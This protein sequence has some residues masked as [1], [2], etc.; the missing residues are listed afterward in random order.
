MRDHLHRR[1]ATAIPEL[2]LNGHPEHRLPNTLHVSFPGVSGRALLGEAADAVAASVGSAC[3]SGHDAVSGVLASMGAVGTT[4]DGV[5]SAAE[6][7]V[8]VWQQT[9]AR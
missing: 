2:K 8:C 6:A 1:L 4:A 3:Q 7:L 5:E 9:H